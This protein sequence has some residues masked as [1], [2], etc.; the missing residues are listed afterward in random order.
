GFLILV[1]K[2]SDTRCFQALCD[3]LR[4]ISLL[5]GERNRDVVFE[6]FH[7]DFI[8]RRREPRS[9]EHVP[10]DSRSQVETARSS[11]LLRFCYFSGARGANLGNRA[12]WCRTPETP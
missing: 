10:L 11:L 1:V 8:L 9:I 12:S 2:H 6:G 4:M 3:H 7:A 5:T